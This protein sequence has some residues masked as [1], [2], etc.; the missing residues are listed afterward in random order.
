[1]T[2]TI[3]A[4]PLRAALT[5]ALAFVADTDD[6]PVLTCINIK[7]VDSGV[8]IAATDRFTLSW[9][10]VETDGQPF[11]L[12]IPSH[13]VRRLLTMLPKGTRRRPL[14][15]AVFFTRD[16]DRVTVE[17]VGG[18]EEFETAITF[19]PPDYEGFPDYQAMIA[20]W[21]E[22]DPA[23]F[24]QELHLNAHYMV[25]VSKAIAA[26]DFYGPTSVRFRKARTPVQLSADGFN[27]IIMPVHIPARA[28]S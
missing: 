18:F 27:A 3:D 24:V 28:E 19:T 16:D 12:L 17:Y 9:E 4:A 7:P 11:S 2:F 15:G 21:S 1:M 26:R 22:F 6:D 25:R 20:R 14:T 5:S 23:D 10:T 8:E 13:I